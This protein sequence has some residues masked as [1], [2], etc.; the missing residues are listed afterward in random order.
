ML[1]CFPNGIAKIATISEL[2]NIFASFF[3]KILSKMF[4]RQLPAVESSALLRF[5]SLF[6]LLCFF[7]SVYLFSVSLVCFPFNLSLFSVFCHSLPN[8][9]ARHLQRIGFPPYVHSAFTSPFTQPLMQP[10]TRTRT[11]PLT[12]TCTSLT[13]SCSSLSF[14]RTFSCR[15]K[16][17]ILFREN[18]LGGTRG[19]KK[20]VL[21]EE[22]VLDGTKRC[23]TWMI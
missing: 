11:Q 19:S 15:I 23:V 6:S 7:L 1:A 2:P 17:G 13:A 14:L 20:L 8:F 21:Y 9:S 4:C 5:S 18:V 10:L 12:R 22:N 3:R 16:N